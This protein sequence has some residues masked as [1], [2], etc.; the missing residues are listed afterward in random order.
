MIR[1]YAYLFLCFLFRIVLCSAALAAPLKPRLV[2]LTDTSTWETDDHESLIRFLAHAD[3]FEILL[4]R[5][6]VK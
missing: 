5:H 6:G 1:K 4:E 2:V 3:M